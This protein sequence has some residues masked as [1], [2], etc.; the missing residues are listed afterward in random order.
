MP[1]HIVICIWGSKQRAPIECDV[2][3]SQKHCDSVYDLLSLVIV[4]IV[5]Q[6]IEHVAIYR[7][8]CRRDSYSSSPGTEDRSIVVLL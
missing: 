5:R 6:T 3:Q 2:M 7:G 8:D 4:G 1:H